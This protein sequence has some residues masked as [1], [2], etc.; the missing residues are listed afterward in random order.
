[1]KAFEY[2]RPV[3]WAQVS[4]ALPAATLKAN[5]IDLLDRMKERVDEPDRVVGLVDV[6]GLADIRVEDD[7]AIEIGASVT[8]HQLA[9]HDA[10][11]AFVPSL[12]EAAG[13]AASA[14]I[15]RRATVGGNLGQHTRCG[16]YRHR[17]FPCLKRG[18]EACPVL[19]DGAVQE[20]A[21]IFGNKTCAS[22]HPSSLAP[23]FGSLDAVV[24]VQ[25][26]KA[27]RNVAF[28]DLWRAPER[29]VATDLSLAPGEWIS[30]VRLPPRDRPQ[31]LAF[32]EVRQMQAFDWALV[33]CAVR[34]VLADDATVSDARIYMGSVAPTPWRAKAAE[35]RLTGEKLTEARVASA[36]EEV[37]R[38]ATP[39]A[40]NAYKVQLAEVAA[41]RAIT[42][43][44]KEAR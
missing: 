20:F 37:V 2:I 21:G 31:R 34:L 17:S 4:P 44:W 32:E 9:I 43:A 13:K 29:G 33:A 5:G 15:R 28:E 39:L 42:R 18:A 12:S 10:L 14:Q 3:S 1:M 41:R 26:P 40:G 25:G 27:A 16:Y 11:R 24:H 8:L 35:L 38:T 30:G 36:A 6:P 7:G 22:A 19:A 23:V